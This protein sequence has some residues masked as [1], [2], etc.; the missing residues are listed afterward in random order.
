VRRSRPRPLDMLAFP[1]L[2]CRNYGGG[3]KRNVRT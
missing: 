1:E 2:G 3:F